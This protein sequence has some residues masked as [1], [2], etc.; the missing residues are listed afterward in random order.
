M[1]DF[2]QSVNITQGVA[3]EGQRANMNPISVLPA[4][5][6]SWHAGAGG[7]TVGRFA[8]HSTDSGMADVELV[9][10]ANSG[11]PVCFIPNHFG[12]A[13]LTDYLAGSSMVIPAHREVGQPIVQGDYWVK[14][15]GSAAATTGMKAYAKLADGTILFDATGQVG[16]H[17]GYVETDWYAATPGAQGELVIM[18]SRVINA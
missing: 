10:A 15:T 11:K 13:M 17:S 16:S 3:S 5:E 12:E 8:W 6:G 18:T 9:N 4:I 1:T 7:L 14:S 2:Q